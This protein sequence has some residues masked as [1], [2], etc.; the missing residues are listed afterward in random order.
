VVR[1]GLKIYVPYVCTLK[2]QD[3]SFIAHTLTSLRIIYLFIYLC[4]YVCCTYI[5]ILRYST[6]SNLADQL[7]YNILDIFRGRYFKR[8]KLDP[9]L[10]NSGL[11]KSYHFSQAQN[12][13]NYCNVWCWISAV[14]RVKM[15]IGHTGEGNQ[16]R[17][18]RPNGEDRA[19]NES[20]R[21]LWLIVSTRRAFITVRI[22]I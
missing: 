7:G 2:V 22:L 13:D 4:I 8:F 20:F 14:M 18:R 12:Y 1:R 21:V 9:P 10:Q 5:L 16:S 11:T 3:S 15:Y 6:S 19:L 17:A